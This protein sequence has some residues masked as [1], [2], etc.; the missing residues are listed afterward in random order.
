M[1]WSVEFDEDFKQEY[2][3]FDARVKEELVAR[4]LTLEEV[5]PQLG[6]PQVDTLKG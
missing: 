1:K 5:G 3:Q 4:A 2:N 6:R